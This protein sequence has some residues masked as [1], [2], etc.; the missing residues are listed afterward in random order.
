[1]ALTLNGCKIAPGRA[2]AEVLVTAEPISFWGGVDPKTG[3]IIDPRHELF[4]REVCGKVLAFPYGKGSSTTSLIILELLRVGK[5]P[6]AIIN[7]HTE[8]ILATG[9][10][11]SRIFY[12]QGIP[13][14]TLAQ[15]DFK[16][17]KTGQQVVVDAD[18][19]TVQIEGQA[20]L[21]RHQQ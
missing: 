12:G 8:P 14:I 3:G 6:A 21:A 18:R 10:V 2:R 15:K 5:A 16:R 4:G 11:V 7:V 9:P 13:M 17:L 20:V 19:G 1:M